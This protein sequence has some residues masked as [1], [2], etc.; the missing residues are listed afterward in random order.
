MPVSVLTVVGARPQFVKAAAVSTAIAASGGSIGE[1]IVH[2]GQHYDARLSEIFFDE[3]V[4]PAPAHNLAVGSAGHGAQTG[5][6]MA[7]LEPIVEAAAPDW[8]LTYGDTNSTLAAALVAAKLHVP[9]AHVEAGLRSFNMRMPEEVNRI[10]TDR[11]SSL[12]LCP[13]DT[14]VAHLA[15][16]GIH[17]GVH[18]VGDVMLDVLLKTA[19]RLSAD[20]DVAHRLG[21]GAG[22]YVVAT[23]HRAENTDDRERFAEIFA[24]LNEIAADGAPVLWPVHPRVRDRLVGASCAA[25]VEAVEVA[26]R[27]NRPAP[28]IYGDG[29]AAEAVVDRLLAAGA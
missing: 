24:A 26:A 18:M 22:D 1:T 28:A 10:V 12:L 11:L 14:A 21:L 6:M 16:E 29:H 27:P 13:S 19:S 15:A 7:R 25:I 4:I 5:E 17:Q 9:V 3:L 2:T 23:I 8:V 20:D